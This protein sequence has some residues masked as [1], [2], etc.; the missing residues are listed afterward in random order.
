[1]TT[2]PCAAPQT[3]LEWF[4]DQSAC[5]K[6]ACVRVVTHVTKM[7]PALMLKG[8][9]TEYATDLVSDGRPHPKRLRL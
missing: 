2:L 8:V 5:A 7:T 3:F 4:Y 9:L 1:M 6:E